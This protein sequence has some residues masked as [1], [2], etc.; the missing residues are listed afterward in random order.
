MILKSQSSYR[1]DLG[2]FLLNYDGMRQSDDPAQTLLDFLDSSYSAAA[3]VA[4]WEH[5]NLDRHDAIGDAAT[6][7]AL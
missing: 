5:S 6:K 7:G 2:E 1:K 4:Q 3:D